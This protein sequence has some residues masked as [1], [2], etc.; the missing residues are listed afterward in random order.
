MRFTVCLLVIVGMFATCC[1]LS[2]AQNVSA[3]DEAAIKSL[4]MAVPEA[5][6]HKDWKAYGD[7]FAEDADWIN[8]VGMF[9]HGKDNVVKAHAAYGT[10]VFRNGGFTFSDLSIRQVAPDVAIVVV[11]EHTVEQVAP[12]GVHKLPAGEDRLSFVV[13]N[14][15]GHWKI[16]LGHNTPVNKAAEPTDPARGWKPNDAS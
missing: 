12:D 9:W 5:M 4:I 11:T 15:S 13:V 16:T 1:S 7:L 3:S 10:T 8:V 6:N 14:R 2:F